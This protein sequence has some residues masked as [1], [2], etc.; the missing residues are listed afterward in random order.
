MHILVD[1]DACPK[2]IKEILFRAAKRRKIKTTLVANLP[3]KVPASLY[4]KTILVP[5]GFNVADE[6]IEELA[7]GHDLVVT[8]DI[9]L[10]ANVI[11]KGAIA[12]NPRGNLYTSENIREVLGMRNLMDE[13]RSGG[14]ETGGPAAFNAKDREAFANKLDQI[15]NKKM[16]NGKVK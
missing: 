2:P 7:C 14:L 4:I 10:A 16:S 12:L 6:K 9:P 3:I 13:L 5:G 8:A 1:A 11:A 15:L